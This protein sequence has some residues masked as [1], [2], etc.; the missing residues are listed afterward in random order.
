MTERRVVAIMDSIPL[1]EALLDPWRKTIGPAYPGYRHHVYR[2]IHFCLSLRDCTPVEREKIIVAGAFHDIGIWIAD[3]LDYLEPSLPPA[4][5]YLRAN[6]LGTWSEE[7]RLMITQHHKICPYDNERLP[8]VEIFRKGDLVDFSLGLV[9]FGLPA[10]YIN[11]VKARFPNAG[12]H[13][14]L[15]GRAAAWCLRHPLDPLPM[16]KV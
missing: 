16:M 7:I 12:F 11:A 8:L 1:L 13:R 10:S 2:M 5:D 9:R 15:A 4:M 3:T 14:Y 6:D